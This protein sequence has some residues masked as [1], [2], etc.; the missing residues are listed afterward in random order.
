MSTARPWITCDAP[1][2]AKAFCALDNLMPHDSVPN[3][4]FDDLSVTTGKRGLRW[5]CWLHD[6]AVDLALRWRYRHEDL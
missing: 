4:E 3:P 1:L 6:K 2:W 5:I